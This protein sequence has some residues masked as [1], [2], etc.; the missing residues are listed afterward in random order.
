MKKPMTD[1]KFIFHTRSPL[2]IYKQMHKGHVRLNIDVHGSPYKSGQG[3]LYVGDALYSPGMLH[4]W[5]KT[6][7]DLKSIHY[8]R[9]VSCFSAY[10]GGGSF[11]CRLSRLIP[12]VYIKGYMDEV[13]SEMS[14]EAI[15]FGL[16]EYGPVKTAAQLQTFFPDGP[17]PLDKFDEKFCSVTY[18]NGVL[19]KKTHRKSK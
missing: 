16:S 15:G 8:I 3:G 10:G 12:D 6:V 14:P 13:L 9:L 7:V 17:P 2:T 11:V 18:K 1:I 4:D 5:L 19:I